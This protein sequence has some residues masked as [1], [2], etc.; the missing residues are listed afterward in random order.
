[1]SKDP[2]PGEQD[3]D[4]DDAMA[5]SRATGGVP[6]AS[7]PDQASTTGTTVTPEYVGRIAGDDIGYVEEQGGERQVQW[8][9][10]HP[11][12]SAR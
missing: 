9:K 2:R 3:V 10:D 7:C 12:E 5:L 8:E 4:R 11:G 1:M 6:D